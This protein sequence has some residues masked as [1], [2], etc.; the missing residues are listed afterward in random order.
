MFD[1]LSLLLAQTQNNPLGDLTFE[2]WLVL[3]A[4][5]AVMLYAINIFICMLV[6]FTLAD[7]PARHRT[8]EP[9]S[10]FL[11]LIPGFNFVWNFYV[12]QDIPK[13]YSRA[14]IARG[15]T[16]IGDC[17]KRVGLAFAIAAACSI[18]PC[19]GFLAAPI[20]LILLI[21]YLVK[22][23]SLKS[24]LNQMLQREQQPAASP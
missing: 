13:S 7:I 8:M 10:V 17:G 14:F 11:L 12:F 24:I 6:Y 22:T 3:F 21:V 1:S 16:D 4:S 2:G 5:L 19:I 15:R 20:A 23:W 9:K 18:I